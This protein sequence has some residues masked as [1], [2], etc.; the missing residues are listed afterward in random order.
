MHKA[1]DR[2]LSLHDL[3][4]DRRGDT[5]RDRCTA[6]LADSDSDAAQGP[7]AA[8]EAR[9]NLAPVPATADLLFLP[10]VL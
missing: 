9:S 1:I 4:A 10:A 2:A 3:R 5:G 7:A 6:D 8:L